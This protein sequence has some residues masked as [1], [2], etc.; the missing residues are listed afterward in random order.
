MGSSGE[1][2]T[3][4]DEAFEADRFNVRVANS[5]NHGQAGQNVLYGDTHVEFVTT[6]YCGVDGDNI[7][8]AQGD[9]PVMTGQAPPAY[10][11]RLSETDA[12]F[13]D[14]DEYYDIR[15]SELVLSATPA[16]GQ[17]YKLWYS[18][19]HSPLSRSAPPC[20]PR[21]IASR[22]F[23]REPVWQWMFPVRSCMS[24]NLWNCAISF[25]KTWV[26]SLGCCLKSVQD[27]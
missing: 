21:W 17:S 26:R 6:P 11:R 16:S 18:A 23:F 15:Q 7:Y 9:R 5:R 22:P 3:A 10:L 20:S 13:Q 24:M 4:L 19:D 12:A 14:A 25:P 8:T 1:A 2:K 27:D